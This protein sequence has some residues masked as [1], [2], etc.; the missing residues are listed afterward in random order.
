[1]K[2]NP[3]F[4][5]IF[6]KEAQWNSLNKDW[7]ESKHLLIGIQFLDMTTFAQDCTW[8]CNNVQTEKSEPAHATI[9]IKTVS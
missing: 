9:L 6:W 7:Q 5:N 4:L 1:M 8:L 2:E 3:L